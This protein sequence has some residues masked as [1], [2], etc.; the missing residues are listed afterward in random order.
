MSAPDIYNKNYSLIIALIQQI[1]KENN[2]WIITIQKYLPVN[3]DI[4]WY[5]NMKT[6]C[7]Q[8]DQRYAKSI[9]ERGGNDMVKV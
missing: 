1:V 2:T 5:L 9:H 6:G 3:L 7:G 8:N 4:L